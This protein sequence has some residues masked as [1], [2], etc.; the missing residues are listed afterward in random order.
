MPDYA[1]PDFSPIGDLANIYRQSQQRALGDQAL[2]QFA[3][4]GATDPGA[5]LRAA[6]ASGGDPRLMSLANLAQAQYLHS[7]EYITKAKTAEAE[8]AQKFAPKTQLL[9]RP[10]GDEVTVVP[11][12]RP[13]EFQLPQVQGETPPAAGAVAIP[14]APPGADVKEWRKLNTKELVEAQNA[15]PTV[16]ATSAQA[17]KTIDEIQNDPYKKWATGITSPLAKIPGTPLFDFGQKVEQLKGKTFLEAYQTL[18]GGGAITEVEGAKATVAIGRLNSAQ[19]EAGFDAA[20][21]DLKDV[22]KSGLERA[23]Q[24]AKPTAGQPAQPQAAAPQQQTAQPPIPG[25]RQGRKPDGSPG[26]FIQSGGKTYLVE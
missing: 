6:A 24:K 17:L 18:K 23:R 5:L 21:N 26:W 12:S 16:E 13:G 15:L 1:S 25:A 9:K 8:V 20:L 11:G 22:I 19:T 2:A 3:S 7:P 4:G 14:P 10:G